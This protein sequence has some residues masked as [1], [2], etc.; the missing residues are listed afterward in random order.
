MTHVDETGWKIGG[1]SAW[2]W[3]FTNDDI[4]LA[5]R[6]IDPS[7]AHEVVEGILGTD[8]AGVLVSDCYVAWPMTR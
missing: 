8:Y 6:V 7:R 2:L 3:V 4:S 5:L 1:H